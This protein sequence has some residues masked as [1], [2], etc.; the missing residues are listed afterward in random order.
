MIG[1][2]I[3]ARLT[4]TRLPNKVLL[5]IEGKAML[6]RV[7]ERLKGS[8]HTEQ[9]IIAIPVDESNDR[10]ALFC[11]SK[12]WPFFRGSEDDVLDRYF[13]TAKHFNLSTV[14]RI[15]SDC[16]FCDPVLVDDVID[17]FIKEKADFASN[18]IERTFP[19]GL[20][21]E[22]FSFKALEQVVKLAKKNYQKEHVTPCFFENPNKFKVVSV[23]AKGA[24]MR[25][26]LRLTV[27]VREDLALAKV[28]YKH[29]GERMFFAKDITNFL[30]QNPKIKA[31]NSNIGQKPL[32][33]LK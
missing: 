23:K 18:A 32:N 19:R 3:Q 13:Q 22:V 8:K 29:F 9:I 11:Q 15:T 27:D 25:P 12:Q 7:V 16:P 24:L 10:L 2:I 20:D 21:A 30:D 4:S 26:E 31:I 5:N 28:I 1:A 14:V 6:E 17:T 33:A